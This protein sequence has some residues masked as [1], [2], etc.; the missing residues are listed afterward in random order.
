MS[1]EHIETTQPV[2]EPDFA[3]FVAIDWGDRKHFWCWQAAGT[4]ERERGETPHTPEAVEAWV[5]SFGARFGHRP[6]AV[7]V[8]QARGPLVAMLSKYAQLHVYPIHPRSASQFR[9]ALFPSGAKDDPS[10]ADLLLD[11]LLHHRSRLRRLAP[12]TEETRSLQLLVEERRKMVDEKTRQRNRL[13]AKLKV[14]FPQV[15]MWF[16]A[17]D[18]LLV[19]AFLR[20]WP[21]LAAVQ[22]SRPATLRQFFHQHNCRREERIQERLE[23]IA[24]ALPATCDPAVIRSA[25]AATTVLLELIKV[26]REGI[27]AMDKQIEELTVAHPDFAIFDSLPGAGT[28]LA[29]RLI[30]A[31]GSQRDRFC[32]AAEVHC[33]TG[34]APV[35][36]RSGK[37]HWTHI[38]RACSKF[39][40]QTFHEWAGHSIASSDWA[41]AYYE[42]QRSRGQDHHAAVRALAFKWIRI[43]FRCWKD[44]QLYDEQIYQNAVRRR[45]R[46]RQ[47]LSDTP[48]ALQWKKCAEFSTPT[49]LTS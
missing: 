1:L 16:D 17:V 4:Q 37:K 24:Q 20:K 40:R 18:T 19:R 32:S 12:D 6:I 9:G 33:Y 36:Q 5:R 11:L 43:V 30:A 22:R 39:V 44:R 42:Q 48:D 2:T 31:M 13:T 35:L 14:Y 41:R 15:L 8:E 26:L 3:A 49:T 7:A 46:P 29:P 28:V 45:Q 10:D 38:R 25:V 47:E 34:I 21:T 23:Q 27:A